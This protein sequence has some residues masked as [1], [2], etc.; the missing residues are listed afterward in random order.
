MNDNFDEVS[1]HPKVHFAVAMFCYLIF[2]S[3]TYFSAKRSSKFYKIV[4]LQQNLM[5]I[6][7]QFILNLTLLA[8]IAI[9]QMVLNILLE[10]FYY[11]LGPDYVY[12]I[13]IAF[14]LVAGF[15]ED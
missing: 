11:K 2:Q 13:W 9:D 14:W 12:N 15:G 6:N 7:L 4:K 3:F 1:V 8:I 10:T 5:T